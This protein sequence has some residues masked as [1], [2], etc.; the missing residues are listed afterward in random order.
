MF[1]AK[2]ILGNLLDL[3]L[4]PEPPTTQTRLLQEPFCQRCAQPVGGVAEGEW[5][6]SNC[7]GLT[8]YYD[9]AR[10][11]YSSQGG[12]QE[13]I[14]RFKYGKEYHLRHRLADWLN[15]GWLQYFS[16]SAHAAL[17]PVPL[18]TSRKRWREFN[19]S[20]ELAHL[21]SR[22]TGVPVWD[23]LRR[24]RATQAQAKLHREDR[25]SNVRGAFVLAK[26]HALGDTALLMV[27]DVFTT[28]STINECARV[29]KQ[30]GA[31]RVDALCVARA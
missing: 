4:P 16:T 12:V 18:H 11:F 6:C 7:G 29:L 2:K 30:A 8:L 3:V 24:D 5:T 21:L 20:A 19:Q 10:A 13:V 15:E 14:H 31:R 17:V 23:C 26:G 25:R 1:S 28:G 9:M 22:R 27:D